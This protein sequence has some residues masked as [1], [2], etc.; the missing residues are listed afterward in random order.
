M[1]VVSVNIRNNPDMRRE[2][3]RQSASVAA[4][5]GGVV[6]FQEI[7]EREDHEDVLTA[8]GSGWTVAHPKLAIPIA[9]RDR[10]WRG[11][12]WGYELMH[13]GKKLT[14]PSRYISWV[15][16]ERINPDRPDRRTGKQVV[17]LNTHFVSGAWSKALKLNKEW[18][19]EMWEIHW[20]K[21]C[22]RVLEFNAA[23]DTVIFGGDFNRMSVRR[24][25]PAQ[26][27]LA[28]HAIDRI[29]VLEG[30]TGPFVDLIES[31]HL[32][33]PSDHDAVVAAIR[34]RREAGA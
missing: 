16:L 7:G 29:G 31:Y 28:Q 15:K 3:V 5:N 27:W 25:H 10:Y 6:M 18:R 9:Y 1:R 12:D 21:M 32:D 20:K 11:L 17:F 22:E 23:G 30:V 26:R 4:R 34:L 8:L 19:K 33:V 24:F 2:L 14:S 13:Q